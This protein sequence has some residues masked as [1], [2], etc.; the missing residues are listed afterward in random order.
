[1]RQQ[2]LGS[3][4]AVQRKTVKSDNPERKAQ[5]RTA[6]KLVPVMEASYISF[7]ARKGTASLDEDVTFTNEN[8]AGILQNNYCLHK[9]ALPEARQ[10]AFYFI[11]RPYVKLCPWPLYCCRHPEPR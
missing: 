6:K 9:Q 8:R 7:G 1:M 4:K 5:M 11:L 3:G 2:V 10:P